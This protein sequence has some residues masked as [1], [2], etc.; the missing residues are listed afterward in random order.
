MDIAEPAGCGGCVQ[1]SVIFAGRPVD[2][3]VIAICGP[4]PFSVPACHMVPRRVRQGL[5]PGGHT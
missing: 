4:M 2:P 3:F 5:S 1:V